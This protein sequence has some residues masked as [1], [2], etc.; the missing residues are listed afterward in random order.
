MWGTELWDQR[1]FDVLI[2]ADVVYNEDSFEALVHTL[3]HASSLDTQIIL[4]VYN[5]PELN[6]LPDVFSM[7]FVVDT[8]QTLETSTGNVTIYSLMRIKVC[9]QRVQLESSQTVGIQG[10]VSKNLG[11]WCLEVVV[12]WLRWHYHGPTNT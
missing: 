4:S 1:P 10:G 6:G 2:G 5:Y 11:L 3:V 7:R 12:D 8:L 9:W